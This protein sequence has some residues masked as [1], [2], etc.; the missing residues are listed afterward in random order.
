MRGRLG[1]GMGERGWERGNGRGEEGRRGG[2]VLRC[3]VMGDTQRPW[4]MGGRRTE[5]AWHL[6]CYSELHLPPLSSVVGG[7]AP[8]GAHEWWVAHE[9]VCGAGLNARPQLQGMMRP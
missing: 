5:A 2:I 8:E 7:T 6:S 9:P 3:N 4:M 1:G